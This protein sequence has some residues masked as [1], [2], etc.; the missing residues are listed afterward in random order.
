LKY[1]NLI[2]QKHIFLQEKRAY[3]CI[4]AKKVVILQRKMWTAQF[5]IVKRMLTA[6]IILMA[7]LTSSPVVGASADTTSAAAPKVIILSYHKS[8]GRTWPDAWY[9]FQLEKDGRYT[10]SNSTQRSRTKAMKAEVPADVAD[11]LAKIVIEE[12]MKDYEY[13]Y[14]PPFQVLDGTTWSLYVRFDDKTSCVSSGYEAWPEGNGLKRLQEYLREVWLQV[15]EKAE[16]IDLW[17]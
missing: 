4:Y 9:D 6:F 12:N 5:H 15:E 11:S 2:I 17:K 3:A 8:D 10:L 13:S 1:A 14:K 7:L 16:E